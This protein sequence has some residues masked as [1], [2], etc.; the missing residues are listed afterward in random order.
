[1][2][3]KT[4]LALTALAAFNNLA[5]AQTS[6]TALTEVPVSQTA[7]SQ[8]AE[9]QP[10]SAD[11]KVQAVAAK[12]RAMYPNTRVTDIRA[13][14][15]DGI[16]EVVMGQNVAYT[17]ATGHYFIFGHLFDMEAQVDITAQ[18][19]REQQGSRRVEYPSAL[20]GNAIKTVKGNGSRQ[21]VVFSD[22]NC[23]YCKRLEQELT[24]VDNVTIYTFLYPVLGE[25]SK[26]LSIATWCAGDR[27]KAWGD[28]ML[29]QKRPPL[30]A[31]TTP[32]NDNTVL[33][34]R[35]GVTGTPT[36][37]AADGRMLPGAAP[38]EKINEWLDSQA[39]QKPVQLSYQGD[40][41]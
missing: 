39:A 16:Y 12:F 17:D 24:K 30:V 3:I 23:P 13:S 22:P 33:G 36:L 41:K 8:K 28:L 7:G 10:G 5:G 40:A 1:M 27:A 21:L 20:L 35:L 6:A 26:T 34:S 37:I 2:K 25:E 15:I 19:E 32:I 38:A 4:L 31:C 11:Q 9:T 14:G 18:R 29:N